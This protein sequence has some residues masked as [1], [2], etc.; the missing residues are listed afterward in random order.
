MAYIVDGGGRVKNGKIIVANTGDDSLT[1]IDLE[2][3]TKVE[4]WCLKESILFNK[5]INMQNI[6]LGPYEMEFDM[7]GNLYCA[8]IYDNSIL[9]INLEKKE[10]VDILAVGKYPTCIKYFENK[11]FVINSDSNS[12]SIVDA[13]NFTLEE[14]IQV[15]EKPIDLEIDKK[16]KKIY[17]AN[18]YGQCIDVID[19]KNYGR[20][21]IKLKSTPV[22]MTIYNNKLLV[23]TNI[24]NGNLNAR[25]ISNLCMIDLKNYGKK[26][27]QNFSGILNNI[28]KLE[29][30]EIVFATNMDSGYLYKIDIKR[31]NLLSKTY[32]SG[33]P[34]KLKWDGGSLLF[35][36]NISKNLLTLFDIKLNKVVDNIE[37]GKEPNSILLLN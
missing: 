31:G 30:R 27:I 2:N 18:Y 20:I 8:N 32:L 16:D 34:N 7:A 19:L 28:L 35:I 17:I 29:G 9:K 13:E 36:T 15:G 23:L 4:K 26:N 33:M 25:N 5:N 1:I 3:W 21:T 24:N 37:V 12:I 6:Y 10:I 14:N 22:K 11:L